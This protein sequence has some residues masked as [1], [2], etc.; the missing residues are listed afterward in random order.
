MR[1][2]YKALVSAKEKDRSTRVLA[3][4]LGSRGVLQSFLESLLDF[5]YSRSAP[6]SN[7]NIAQFKIGRTDCGRV[8]LGDCS[9][10]APSDP[11]VRD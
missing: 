2:P 7:P 4:L 5:I 11:D 3:E 9:P 10:R 1:R 8:A 6:R